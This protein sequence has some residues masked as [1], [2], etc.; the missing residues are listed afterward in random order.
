M[1]VFPTSG[2]FTTSPEYTGSFIPT[3]WS[4][5]L[6]AKFYQ[7]TM[8]SEIMNT[9]YEGELKNKGDT[10]RIRTAPSI[11]IN[12][13]TGAGSTLATE[14]PVPIFQDMQVN[15]A[16]YFSV[17]TNDVLAQQADMDLMNMFTED[18]AKQLKIA[19]EDEVFFNTFVTNGPAAANAGGT[20]GAISANYNLG[21]D[22]APVAVSGAASAGLLNTILAMS[23]ALDE[24]NVPEDGRFLVISPFDRQILMQTNI[25]Q[26]YF[27]G[28][29]S[30]I[31]R[32]GKIGMLDRFTVY[33][34]NLLPKGAAAKALVPGLSATSGGATLT[35]AL[36]RRTMVAGTKHACS[37]A[38]TI[39]KTEP[40][41]NQTDFGDIVRGLAVYGRKVVKNEALIVAKVA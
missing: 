34:S 16:K 19:I 23:A 37:F 24:Q 2:D 11:T 33:V 1:A 35:D 18:A 6:L 29:S 21:T 40:L 17:Q 9:D 39:S 32:T 4:G 12:D 15:K 28:D 25:A 3:L 36:A 22:L 13:Y 27:T 14:V 8:L 30:S 38:M 20:A 7:N 26:A 41:R 5:K 10:I 31:I